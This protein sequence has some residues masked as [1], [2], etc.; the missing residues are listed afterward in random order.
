[1]PIK[2]NKH[3]ITEQNSGLVAVFDTAG[4]VN[5]ANDQKDNVSWFTNS[6]ENWFIST[7]IMMYIKGQDTNLYYYLIF[8]AIWL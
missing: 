8:I 5:P 7:N 6:E 1:M 2:C 3:L 4:K